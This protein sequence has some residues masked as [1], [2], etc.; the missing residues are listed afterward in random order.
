MAIPKEISIKLSKETTGN[1]LFTIKLK[2]G[3]VE[4]ETASPNVETVLLKGIR[5]LQTKY[6]TKLKGNIEDLESKIKSD[7]AILADASLET[8]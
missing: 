8:D 5:Y 7:K 1:K 2:G 4:C 3:G 6:D